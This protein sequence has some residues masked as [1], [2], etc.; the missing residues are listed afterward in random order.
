[1]VWLIA[2]TNDLAGSKGGEQAVSQLLG[3]AESYFRRLQEKG[4]RPDDCLYTDILP[5]AGTTNPTFDAD[6][7]QFNSQVAARLQ[8]LAR[9][10]PSGE[11]SEFQNPDDLTWFADGIHPTTRGS[12]KLADDAMQ[13]IQRP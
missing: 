1:V 4:Y 13:V 2:G 9:V 7:R 8:G 5:R 6:R 3:A 10:V 12:R 11:D